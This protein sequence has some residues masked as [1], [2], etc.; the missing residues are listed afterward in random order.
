MYIITSMEM[1]LEEPKIPLIL[2]FSMPKS[3]IRI[4]T[5]FPTD[6][7]YTFSCGN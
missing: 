3:N 1:A 2:Y 4:F 7:N 6:K 5:L